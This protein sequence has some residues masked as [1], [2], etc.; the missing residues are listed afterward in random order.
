MCKACQ[1]IHWIL[2]CFFSHPFQ[3]KPKGVAHLIEVANPNRTG[4]KSAKKVTEMGDKP[5]SGNLSRRER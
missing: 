4:A 3:G 1:F 2:C 5:A